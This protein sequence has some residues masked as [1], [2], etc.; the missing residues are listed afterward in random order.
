[1]SQTVT[2]HQ[3][4]VSDFI[5]EGELGNLPKFITSTNVP[6]GKMFIVNPDDFSGDINSLP[7]RTTVTDKPFCG[8]SESGLVNVWEK[9]I[10]RLWNLGT[11]Y[12][13]SM[14]SPGYSKLKKELTRKTRKR[15]KLSLR[16]GVSNT[17]T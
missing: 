7:P 6:R 10:N 17:L 8:M 3:E 11:D 9:P 4:K 2:K 14:Y 5:Q 15:R 1:M 16:V 12:S 13:K